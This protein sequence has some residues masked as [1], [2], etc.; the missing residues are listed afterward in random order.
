[1]VVGWGSKIIQYLMPLG[2]ISK[3]FLWLNICRQFYLLFYIKYVSEKCCKIFLGAPIPFKKT[4]PHLDG[5]L[6]NVP[7]CIQTFGNSYTILQI[8]ICVIANWCKDD[9]TEI[10]LYVCM[11]VPSIRKCSTNQCGGL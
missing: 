11:Y 1:M 7:M 2:S 10:C 8:F 4:K 9:K 3:I 6:L 5:A